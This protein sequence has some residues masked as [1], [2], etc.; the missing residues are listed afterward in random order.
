MHT[1][2]LVVSL[3]RADAKGS[4][5]HGDYGGTQTGLRLICHEELLCT[6]H[7]PDAELQRATGWPFAT[8][9]LSGR[10]KLSPSH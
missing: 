9:S 6:V 1:G 7:F 4:V 3:I 8:E 5:T 10:K 2:L